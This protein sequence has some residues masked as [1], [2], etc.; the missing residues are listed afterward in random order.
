MPSAGSKDD[1]LKQKISSPPEGPN[2]T[3]QNAPNYNLGLV[4]TMLGSQLVHF[5]G[6][7]SQAQETSRY[8]NLVSSCCSLCHSY[9]HFS[10]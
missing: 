8:S 2:P 10:C 5:E 4:S 9:I 6:S 1:E 3:V 7:E